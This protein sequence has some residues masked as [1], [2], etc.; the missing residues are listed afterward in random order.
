MLLSN[1]YQL[2][3]HTPY[4]FLQLYVFPA[5]SILYWLQA[6]PFI[7]MPLSSPIPRAPFLTQYVHLTIRYH[8]PYDSPTRVLILYFPLSPSLF[9]LRYLNLW[10]SL[11][12]LYYNILLFTCVCSRGL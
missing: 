6:L 8:I 2:L 4:P 7:A 1:C 9:T 3:Q 5:R 11:Q 10:A 12:L